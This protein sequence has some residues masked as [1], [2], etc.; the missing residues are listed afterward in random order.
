AGGPTGMLTE[1]Q[2]NAGEIVAASH[3]IRNEEP[4]RELAGLRGRNQQHE[5]LDDPTTVVRALTKAAAA[6]DDP[7]IECQVVVPM[8]KAGA[9][10]GTKV[11]NVELQRQLNPN[12]K[13][14]GRMSL[15][16][17]VIN[18]KNGWYAAIGPETPE[19]PHDA[20]GRVYV[21]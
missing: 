11:L 5:S 8:A 19:A 6:P 14:S 17:K 1:V 15:G 10:Y 9:G 21:A 16:D 18:T 7:A 12:V 3:R 20:S 4:W 2:R 13:Q